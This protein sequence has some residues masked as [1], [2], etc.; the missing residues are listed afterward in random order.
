MN[1]NLLCWTFKPTLFLDIATYIYIY[2]YILF[3]LLIKPEKQESQ[4]IQWLIGISVANLARK[5]TSPITS[6]GTKTEWQ[7][8]SDWAKLYKSSTKIL[9]C[10]LGLH[11]LLETN[12]DL[13]LS[14]RNK[15]NLNPKLLAFTAAS[16]IASRIM[17]APIFSVQLDTL[18]KITS[19]CRF[20]AS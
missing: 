1:V 12:T 3:F 8:T 16:T 2:I 6:F 13:K 19:P 11:I 15:R 20:L 7:T 10:Q 9:S 4:T 5:L 14:V 17:R 18:C